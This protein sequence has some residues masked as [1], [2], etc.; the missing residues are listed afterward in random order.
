ML[1]L[2]VVAPPAAVPLLEDPVVMTAPLVAVAP[3]APL[4][5]EVTP[6]AV[7]VASSLVEP[8]VSASEHAA[9]IDSP[10]A[11]ADTQNARLF[12]AGMVAKR[13]RVT[14]SEL[15]ANRCCNFLR[16]VQAPPKI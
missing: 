12:M 9:S 14:E 6:E 1:V 13:A 8:L 3:P 4:E 11:L 5:V 2:L 16:E 10:A 7:D 15:Q